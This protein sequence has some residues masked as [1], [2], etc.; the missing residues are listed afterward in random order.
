MNASDLALIGKTPEERARE[1]QKIV[2]YFKIS[3][4]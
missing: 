1:G 3:S 2:N 4:R